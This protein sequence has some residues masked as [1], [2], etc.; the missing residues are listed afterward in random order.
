MGRAG[1]RWDAVAQHRALLARANPT[2]VFTHFHSSELEDGSRD[3]QERRFAAALAALPAVPPLVHAENGAAVERRAPSPWSLCR[4]GVF[5]YGVANVEGGPLVPEPVAAVR[6][7]IVELRTVADGE[8]VS[9]GATW[10]ARGERRIATVPVGYADGYRR[11]LSN[12]AE[13]LLNGRRIPVAG[14]V[15]MDMTMFDVTDTEA[16]L[17]D[18]VTLLGRDGG[19]VITVAELAQRSELSPY[20]I[21]TGLRE[22]LP[23]RYVHVEQGAIAA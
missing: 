16:A 14:R 4:P 5:L 8:P 12:R 23:R 9:Y 13:A 15:T 20:E 18:V 10:R 1:M 21:L 7:R 19:E 3:E 22:R 2:G 17:G 6:A 11:S